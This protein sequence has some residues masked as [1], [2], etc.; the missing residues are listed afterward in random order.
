MLLPFLALSLHPF[1]L[2]CGEK[3][4]VFL[5]IRDLKNALATQEHLL[6]RSI[7]LLK[8]HMISLSSP[9]KGHIL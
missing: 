7:V 5:D 1:S 2:E 3:N 6:S 9:Q 4:P 8:I